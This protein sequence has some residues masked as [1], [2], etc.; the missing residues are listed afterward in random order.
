MMSDI[1]NNKI[2]NIG[3]ILNNFVGIRVF[4]ISD[5]ANSNG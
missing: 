1:V 3:H 5:I 4:N 2:L